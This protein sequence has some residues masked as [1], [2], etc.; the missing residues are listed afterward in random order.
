MNY[1]PHNIRFIAKAIYAV[2]AQKLEEAFRA[3]DGEYEHKAPQF[4]ELSVNEQQ[5][6]ME[7]AIA[8]IQAIPKLIGV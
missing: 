1:A 8:A 6:H 3:P 2:S 5:L 7:Y 4:E